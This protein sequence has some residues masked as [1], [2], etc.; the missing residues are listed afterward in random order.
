MLPV[1]IEDVEDKD[2]RPPKRSRPEPSSP[3]QIYDSDGREIIELTAESAKKVSD[4]AVIQSPWSESTPLFRRS[5]SQV[6]DR[7]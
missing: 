3:S 4:G 7:A 6:M 5:P 2:Y 1:A